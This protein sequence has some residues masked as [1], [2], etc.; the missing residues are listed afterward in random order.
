M[1][2]TSAE[3]ISSIGAIVI[4][5]I[6]LTVMVVTIIFLSK[7]NRLTGETLGK[8]ESQL[9]LAEKQLQ[10][11]KDG[12]NNSYDQTCS[13]QTVKILSN[14]VASL[15][16]VETVFLRIVSKLDSANCEKLYKIEDCE[17]MDLEEHLKAYLCEEC[18]SRDSELCSK[19]KNGKATQITGSA[20]LKLRNS[21]INF[22]NV[23]EIV[24]M[25]INL[26]IIDEERMKQECEFLFD[27]SGQF[28][29]K[30]FREKAGGYPYLDAFIASHSNSSPLTQKEKVSV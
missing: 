30:N 3:L 2:A 17:V 29:L 15:G 13:I 21:A 4:S 1:N 10:L 6:S 9:K 25:A 12:M 11:M 20:L 27:S 18:S 23:S 26:N 24:M 19:C 8:V 22:L 28:S 5:V 16:P 7:Q 14:W